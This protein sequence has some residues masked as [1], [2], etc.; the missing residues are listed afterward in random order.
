MPAPEPDLAATVRARLEET[1]ALARCDGVEIRSLRAEGHATDKAD[2][3]SGFDGYF[4]KGNVT[5][6]VADRMAQLPLAGTGKG[7][8]A[9]TG[10]VDMATEQFAEALVKQDITRDICSKD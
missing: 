3:S 9:R 1:L 5:L 2:S 6:A 8:F 4:L 10:A 7:P